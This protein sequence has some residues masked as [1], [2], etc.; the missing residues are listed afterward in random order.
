MK[1]INKRTGAIIDCNNKVNSNLWELAEK[2]APSSVEN[3]VEEPKKA[4]RTKKTK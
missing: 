3:V 1:Y 4:P 2:S